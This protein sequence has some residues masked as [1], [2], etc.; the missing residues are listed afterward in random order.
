[1]MLWRLVITLLAGLLFGSGLALSGML[2]PARVLGF[3]DLA[4]G[5]WDPSL[6]LVLGGALLVAM[7]AVQ[8][9][10][11]LARSLL[12]NQFHLPPISPV[13]RRL[14]LG[15]ALFGLGWG[16]AGLCPGPALA[17]LGLGIAKIYGFVAALV[18]GMM[19]HDRGLAGRETAA[20]K[21]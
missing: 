12:D 14:V 9:Q 21:A 5:H 19:L 8:L 13:D 3:L 20:P 6:L 17:A 10:R 2:D 16:L 18:A 15:A 4:S 11:R 7:P 1:M